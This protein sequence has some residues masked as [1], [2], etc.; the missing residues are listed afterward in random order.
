VTWQ[1]VPQKLY[2]LR[3][4]EINGMKTRWLLD[5]RSKGVLLSPEVIHTTGMK[6]FALEQ[7]I[8]LQ[9][10]CIGSWSMINYRTNM[11]IRFSC[12]TYEEYFNVANIEY[13]DTIL[14]TLFLRKL[15]II[16][17]F[18]HPGAVWIGNENVPIWK[19]SFNNEVL[20]DGQWL[21][22]STIKVVTHP[23]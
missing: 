20:K 21:K 22:G 11:T 5:S 9:L 6:M 10:A 12:E 17:D 23:G 8:A 4:L 13:Y 14:G 15:G 2:P 7:P 1:A 19:I 16:L 18:S 3:I